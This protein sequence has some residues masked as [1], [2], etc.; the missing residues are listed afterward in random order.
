MFTH[1]EWLLAQDTDECLLNPPQLVVDLV[2]VQSGHIRVRPSV[3][4]ERVAPEVS[5]N[6]M[7]RPYTRTSQFMSLV[8]GRNVKVGY[9]MIHSL[10]VKLS[11][12]INVI[13]DTVVV[14]ALY[15]QLK[16]VQ[17][18]HIAKDG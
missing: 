5:S 7:I 16:L 6:T 18:R 3:R 11:D 14:L 13:V 4:A 17:A 15:H 9:C 8:R 2:S 1:I 10:S 12:L